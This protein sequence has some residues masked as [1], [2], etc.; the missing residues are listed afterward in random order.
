[1][2]RRG[3]F[4][5]AGGNSH[6]AVASNHA[7]GA[8]RA[9]QVFPASHPSVGSAVLSLSGTLVLHDIVLHDTGELAQQPLVTAREVDAAF[10]WAGLLS[11]RMRRIQANGV[12]VHAR[13]NGPSQLSLLD[14]FP[15]KS[16]SGLPAE[17][18]RGT[19]PIWI[20]TLH[21]QGVIHLAPMRGFVSASAD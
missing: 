9:G 19:L 17:A 5:A 14:L 21:V 1:M 13:P 6:G 11:R 12:T 7:V 20:D 15:Q 2:G 10:G 4:A 3:I 16:Q 8:S 18:N